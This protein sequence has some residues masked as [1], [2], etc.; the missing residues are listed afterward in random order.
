[1]E[2]TS[3]AD[4]LKQ[5]M[6]NQIVAKGIEFDWF[7]KVGLFS[8]NDYVRVSYCIIGAIKGTDHH[9]SIL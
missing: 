4:V 9:L 5:I 1:M 7:L 8:T 3:S 2:G 6:Q